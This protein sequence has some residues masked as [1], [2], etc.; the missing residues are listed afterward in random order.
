MV[1]I[2]ILLVTGCATNSDE[3]SNEEQEGVVQQEDHTDEINNEEAEEIEEEQ[4][5]YLTLGSTFEFDDF[6]I[7]L[8]DSI[9]WTTLE[10]QFS[11]MDGSDVFYIPI[12]LTNL[13]DETQ[14]LNM[15]SYTLFGSAGTQLDSVSSFFDDDVAWA[16]DMRPGATLESNLH[17]LYD[18][19]GE[20][21]IEFDNWSESLEVMISVSK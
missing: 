7:T 16:G 6:E 12:T 14:G 20:Y 21:Y 13:S 11:D 4:S 8:G 10:N 2:S 15:F 5:D 19:D 17:I 18:G 9:S 1:L 3:P